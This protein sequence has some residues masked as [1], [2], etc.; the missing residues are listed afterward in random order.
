MYTK[1]LISI[2]VPIY[3]VENYLDDC[4]QSLINQTYKNIEII[5]VDDGSPDNSGRM[6]DEYAAKDNRIKVIHK[7]NGGLVSARNAGYNA[8][9][10]QW[11]MYVDSDDWID[12]KTCELLVD[13]VT[14]NENIDIIFWKV[15]QDLNG[16]HIKGKWEW[17]CNDSTHLYE[18]NECVELA[19]NVLVYKSGI[20]TAY[21]KL[22][23]TQFSREKKIQHDDRLKQGMEGTEYSFRCFLHASTVLY[24]NEYFNY[25]RYNEDSIS[26]TVSEKNAIYITDCI[27]VLEEDLE[28][29]LLTKNKESFVA[30][31]Y[32]R[33]VYS[34]IALSMSTYFHPNNNESLKTKIKKFKN[35]LTNYNFY[36]TSIKHTS[37]KG[38]DISR[39]IVVIILRLKMYFLLP[40]VVRLKVFML[41]RGKYNY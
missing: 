21:A 5:L 28:S 9:T 13:Y 26:K 10:G 40:M 34:L 22:I 14:K 29:P 23:N 3:K 7:E 39:K 15:I 24:V 37:V 33:T 25:Y 36:K 32:Q 27:K 4:V 16:K 30:A 41:K 12:V 17:P 35:L 18:G 1:P 38:M 8:V 11:H 2:I 19:R 6:C 31:L 20:A